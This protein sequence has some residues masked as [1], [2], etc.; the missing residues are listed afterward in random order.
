MEPGPEWTAREC[1]LWAIIQELRARISELEAENARLKKN[2]SNSSKPPSSDIVKPAKPA[3]AGGG[4]KRGIGGQPGHP[5]HERQPFSTDEIDQVQCHTLASGICPGCGG[6]LEPTHEAAKVIQQVELI[7]RPLRVTEHR[8]A[9]YRCTCCGT[10]HQAPLPEAV[11]RG[12]LMGPR[13]TALTA[14]LKGAGHCSYSTI[15]TF[16]GDVLDLSVSRGQLVKTVGKASAALAEPYAALLDALPTE[17]RLNVDET[18]HKDKGKRYWTW[19]FRAAAPGNYTLFK[20]DPSRGSQVLVDTLS[21]DFAGVLGCDYFSAY[22]KF[23]GENNVRVQFCLAHLIRDVKFLAEHPDA[24]ARAYG[25]RLLNTLRD[26]FHTIHRRDAMT[27]ARF[28]KAMQ[29]KRDQVLLTAC[30]DVPQTRAAKN[31]ARRFEKHGRSYFE[32]ITTPDIEPTNNLAEQAIRFVVIDRK[33]TQGTRG[34]VGQRWCERIWTTLATC[35]Q[36]GR[37]AFHFLVDAIIAH[38]HARPTP[39]LMPAGP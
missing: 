12:G 27:P 15:Q 35:A 8:A 39:S 3:P 4:N 13:L 21:A 23:M 2:S 26:L 34:N 37:S 36:Q 25:E 18:G 1:E 11:V 24:A 22:R 20:I 6:G 31:L 17:D 30:F 19:C 16:F 10:A 9:S 33:V 32:F 5:R 14:H 38:L 28:D 29:R 7:E